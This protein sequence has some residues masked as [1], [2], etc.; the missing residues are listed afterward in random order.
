MPEQR[1]VI[2]EIDALIAEDEIET[3]LVASMLAEIDGVTYR[4]ELRGNIAALYVPVTP[5]ETFTGPY[6]FNDAAAKLI[7]SAMPKYEDETAVIATGLDAL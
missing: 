2:S 6:A 7:A 1:N 5:V 4:L 3:D